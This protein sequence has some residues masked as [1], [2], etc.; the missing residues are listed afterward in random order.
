MQHCLVANASRQLQFRP[1]WPAV[2]L[3][4]ELEK[5]IVDTGNK[6]NATNLSDFL[7][8]LRP[9]RVKSVTTTT[10][11]K[12]QTAHQNEIFVEGEHR[13]NPYKQQ[14]SSE[15]REAH[16]LNDGILPFY[17]LP[18]HKDSLFQD[19]SAFIRW[20]ITRRFSEEG[21]KCF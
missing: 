5:F 19:L 8:W 2:G 3:A 21:E 17:P 20:Y 4:Q 9:I 10:K 18:R 6:Q 7:N 12:Y 1:T 14:D 16:T 15:K 13:E 11:K